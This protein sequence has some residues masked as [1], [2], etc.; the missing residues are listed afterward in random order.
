MLILR[1]VDTCLLTNYTALSRCWRQQLYP[2]SV[3]V[4]KFC[5]IKSGPPPKYFSVTK[6][7][8]IR[9]MCGYWVA[10][11]CFVNWGPSPTRNSIFIKEQ[12]VKIGDMS[13]VTDGFVLFIVFVKLMY[14]GRAM[15]ARRQKRR[16]RTSICMISSGNRPQQSIL[17]CSGDEI[18]INTGSLQYSSCVHMRAFLIREFLKHIFKKR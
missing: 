10:H 16:S 3:Y 11:F 4:L 6:D 1:N 13:C 14:N 18:I 7:F 15:T 12:V 5:F 17:C 9:P 2:F 8:E